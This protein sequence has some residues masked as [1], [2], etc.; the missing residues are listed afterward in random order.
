MKFRAD[1][2]MGDTLS[3]G[4]TTCVTTFHDAAWFGT[5]LTACRYISQLPGSKHKVP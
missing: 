1:L 5:M 4:F 2:T 3:L